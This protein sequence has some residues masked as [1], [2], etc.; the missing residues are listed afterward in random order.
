MRPEIKY[1]VITGISVCLW[2]LLEF[3]L[4]FHTT[5]LEFGKY[6]GY[7]ASLIP[8]ILLVLLLQEKAKKQPLTWLT[9]LRSGILVSVIA[10]AIITTFFF[11]YNHYINPGWLNLVF[12]AQKQELVTQGASEESIVSLQEQFA[13]YS[14]DL[15]Q[16]IGGFFSTILM[17]I[18][19]TLII[20][21]FIRRRVKKHETH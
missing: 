2:V 17:G 18:I 16:I 8:I 19:L 5:R 12:E 4:G 10:A 9:A 11:F 20:T 1:G 6:S 14:S 7:V 13:F 15:Y 3:A 21:F